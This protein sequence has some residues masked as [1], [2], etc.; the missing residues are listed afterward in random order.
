M[1]TKKQKIPR[2]FEIRIKVYYSYDDE[3]NIIYDAE[4]M[5]EEFDN[6]LQDL[7]E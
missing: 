6:K 1:K 5:Q 7:V 4:S 3:G 2:C